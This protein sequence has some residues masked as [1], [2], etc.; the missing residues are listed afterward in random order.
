MAWLRDFASSRKQM[1][2][3]VINRDMMDELNEVS[4]GFSKEALHWSFDLVVET[5]LAIQSNAS[6]NLALESLL[7]QLKQIFWGIP[8]V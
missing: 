8:V 3:G 2:S 4:N 1:V 6:K 5:E 7:I